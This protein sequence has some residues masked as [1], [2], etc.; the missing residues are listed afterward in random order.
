[1]ADQ[2]SFNL[3]AQASGPVECL[4]R[5]FPSDQAR[6]EHYLKLLAAKL[7]DPEFRRI[8]GFPAGTDDAILALSN[9][10]YFTACPNPWIG[11]FLKVYGAPYDPKQAYHR[12]PFASD[13]GDGKN[14]PIYNAHSYHT[15]V[16]HRAIMRYILHYTLPGQVVFDGFC[17]TGM[18]GVAAQLCGN[19]SEIQALGYRVLDDGTIL[20]EEGK[21]FSKIGARKPLLSDLSPAA[22]FIAYN[23]NYSDPSFEEDARRILREVEA[24]HGWIFSTLHQPTAAQLKDAVLEVDKT[25]SHSDL[26]AAVHQISTT[27]TRVGRVNYV[28]WSDV[29]VCP[30]CGAEVDFWNQAVVKKTGDVLDEFP[31]PKCKSVVTK[32]AAEPARVSFYDHVL[33]TVVTQTKQ[34]IALVNYTFDGK[35]FEKAADSFDRALAAKLETFPDEIAPPSGRMPDGDES[36]RNDPAGMTHVHHFYSKRN[37]ILLSTLLDRAPSSA[38]TCAI[39]DGHSVGTK[40]SRFRASAW[41]TKSTGPMKGNTAGTLYVP[42]LVGEQNW[43]NILSEKIAMIRRAHFDGSG[44]MIA[45]SSATAIPIPPNSLDYI[46]LDPPF[47]AN[48]LYSEL[49]F[50]WESWLRAWTNSKPE[51]I[52]C[53]AQSKDLDA[54]RGLMADSF[55]LAFQALKP[56][57]WLTVEFSNTKASVWNAIQSAL[58]EC[59]FVVANVSALDKQQGSFKAVTT[60]TAVKQDLVISAY[61]PNGGLEE[62]FA[63][64]GNTVAGVWDFVRTHLRNLPVVKPKGGQLEPIAERDPRILYDRMV[65]FYVGHSTPVPLSSAEFQAELASNFV[66]RDGMWFL[67]E[68]V[69]EYDKKRAQMES[70][71]QLAIFV[72]DERSAIDWLRVELKDKPQTYQDL[73]PDFMQQLNASW[74]KWEARPE[75]KVLLDQNFLCYDGTGEVPSQIHSYL[76]TQFKELRNLPKDHAQLRQKAKDRWYVPDPKKNVDV[77]TLRN[78]RLLE[79]FWSY[80]PDGYISAAR[81]PDRNPTLPMPGM[82][83]PRPKVPRSKKLKQVRTEAVRV[84]FKFCYQQ[85]DYPTILAVAD[86]LPESVLNEDE[87]LQ[88]IYDNAALRAEAAT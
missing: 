75:L 8:E 79:E 58:Q 60:T 9:P 15:K 24:S 28:V 29:F 27:R 49:N 48:L 76:S 68:Q 66:E 17:G 6:R 32:R 81:S 54:Y 43:L 10:P 38:V 56:G 51:A 39:L 31:C 77:E 46:F 36:R 67:P 45:T 41:A 25:A 61:K 44:A 21:A 5:T 18:T 87:Q 7:K 20:N 16:P 40:M 59:G 62:R 34:S 19:R 71:G 80:L 30:E 50:L 35:R 4:G 82:A 26:R 88:M 13:V 65:A 12:E 86:M 78:K 72:E 57:R 63:K 3:S 47:G 33:K 1:M 73:Q 22:S 84:G 52:E 85:K 53:R 83:S 11:E 55:K 2:S 64:T 42:S 69:N 74:K 37:L 23:Y 70:V 14:H